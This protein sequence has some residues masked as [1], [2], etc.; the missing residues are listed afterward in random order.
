MSARALPAAPFTIAVWA[1][2]ALVAYLTPLL[3]MVL[4]AQGHGHNFSAQTSIAAGAI[5][6]AA[7]PGNLCLPLR[8]SI[9]FQPH[10]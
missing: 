3:S 8:S 6:L 2:L 4:L 5:L 1:S 9:N 7:V 10:K